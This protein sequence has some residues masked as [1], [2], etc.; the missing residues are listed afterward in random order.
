VCTYSDEGPVQCYSRY[1][2]DPIARRCV[3]GNATL[4]TDAL[5]REVDR[6]N[7]WTVTTAN[8]Q[9]KAFKW[10][11]IGAA[12][13]FVLGFVYMV[14]LRYLGGVIV[15]LSIFLCWAACAAFS[16]W[17]YFEGVDRKKKA[18]DREPT[19]ESA[20]RNAKALVIL[21]YVALGITFVLLCL[22]VFMFRRIQIAIGCIKHASRAIA[23]M[24]FIFVIPIIT[25]FWVAAIVVYGLFVGAY[26][27]SAG[28]I[29]VEGCCRKF[30]FDTTLTRMIY[31]H[32]FGVV[33][34]A[35]F[36]IGSSVTVVNVAV[37]RF[38]F[39]AKG[40]ARPF[41]PV[42]HATGTVARYHLG[43]VAFGTLVIAIV[44]II[45]IWFAM[46][47]SQLKKLKENSTVRMV[48]C[49]VNCCLSC[50]QRFLEFITSHAFV[51]I[52]ITGKGFCGAAKDAWQLITSNPIRVAAV[53]G[54]SAFVI[55]LGKIFITVATLFASMEMMKTLEDP[56][57]ESWVLY[58]IIALVAYIVADGFLEVYESAVRTILQCFIVDE[59]DAA[60]TYA[61]DDLKRYMKN[62]GEKRPVSTAD[63]SGGDSLPPP[64]PK[65]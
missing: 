10:I 15:W 29:V 17:L 36:V 2:S 33:W 38:Y 28:E 34:S 61:P 49:C 16:A 50:F 41:A 18:D 11:A 7:S 22:I 58:V 60:V 21:S 6:F 54:V 40:E 25:F 27:F 35:L 65:V 57:I 52:A 31:F 9:G 51:Q 62:V 12:M 13:A 47:Q 30:V 23:A 14:L 3:P 48:L 55:V 53:T 32:V 26:L 37:A 59:N 63:G 19:D 39:T 56:P 20:T 8:E 64:P 4:L 44:V 5:E 46:L 24:P 45:R 1:K 42:M 43:S